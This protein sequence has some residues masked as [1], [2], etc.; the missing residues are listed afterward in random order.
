MA[1]TEKT[2][3]NTPMRYAKGWKELNNITTHYGVMKEEIKKKIDLF[4]CII[5]VFVTLVYLQI[6]NFIAYAF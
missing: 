2:T 3:G 4:F 6:L 1:G 5:I